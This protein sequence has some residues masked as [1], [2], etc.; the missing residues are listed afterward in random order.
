MKLIRTLENYVV[1]I[2]T[3]FL[4][5]S[6][7]V[8]VMLAFLQVV[9]R[10]VFSS[11]FLW[12]DTFLRYLVVWVGFIGAAIATKEERHISMEVLTKFISPFSQNIVSLVTSLV[13]AVVCYYLFTASIQFLDISLPDDVRVFGN[14]RLAYFMMIIPIGFLLMIFH[15]VIRAITKAEKIFKRNV[16]SAGGTV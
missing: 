6:L 14:I 16:D 3:I 9:L 11:G 8:M 2:E 4:V 5:V 10:N 7:I 13:A 15:F 1:K 12:A